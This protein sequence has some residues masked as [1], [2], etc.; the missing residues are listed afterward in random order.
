MDATVALGG[1][2]YVFWGGREGYAALINTDMK[3]E[4]EQFARM[5][6]MSVDYGRKI[7]F[8][9]R[10][11][12]EP[13]P[14]EPSTHQYDFDAKLRRGSF[15]LEDLF[16]AHIGGMD[17]F[18]RGLIIADALKQDKRLD[19][20]VRQRY[21]G[22]RRGVGK[23]IMSDK[24]DLKALENTLPKKANRNG[25]ADVRRCWKTF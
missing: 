13:K 3:Q 2:G 21:A 22:Y 20:F 23:A 9:G 19:Q 10:F 5:L 6:H 24:T 14:K 17:T 11:F 4:R 7:G 15:D 16:H 1:T 18:A 8:K 12:I 25:S